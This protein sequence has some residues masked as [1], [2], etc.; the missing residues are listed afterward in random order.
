MPVEKMPKV[1]TEPAP[2]QTRGKQAS[3]VQTLNVRGQ[4]MQWSKLK[5][6]V[7]L[8]ICP[9]LRDV[10]DFHVTRYRKAHSWIS[11]SWV[12]VNGQRVF[13]CGSRTYAR[14]AAFEFL[15][16]RELLTKS[17]ENHSLREVL[18]RREIHEP[19]FMGKSLRAYLDMPIDLALRSDNP[20]IKAFAVIDRR[21]GKQRLLKLSLEPGVHSLVRMFYQL[22]SESMHLQQAL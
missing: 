16:D 3:L 4:T 19:Q 20:F 2:E 1:G 8:L 5:T 22:R 21:L 7:R 12:T 10:V 11:E 13:D 17:E 18:Q 9:E 14:E 6:R 15:S